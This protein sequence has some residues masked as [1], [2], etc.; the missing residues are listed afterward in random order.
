MVARVRAPPQHGGAVYMSQSGGGNSLLQ[1]TDS[2]FMRNNASNQGGAVHT[3]GA[4]VQM[5]N[6]VFDS[7]SAGWA[8][9][10]LSISAHPEGS[11]MV[12]CTFQG[13]P[14]RPAVSA[15]RVLAPLPW[16]CALG[17]YMPEF[18]DFFGDFTG[19]YYQCAPGHFGNAS[20][21]SENTCA[22]ECPRGMPSGGL[23]ARRCS[24]ASRSVLFDGCRFR[25]L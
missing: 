22:G 9:H 7:G 25:R 17:T 6:V 2:N 5:A 1:I 8:A 12:N 15:V 24:H 13:Y 10:A 19:C 21:H 18:G 16:Y 11:L 14:P 20:S 3:T 23:N 4:R